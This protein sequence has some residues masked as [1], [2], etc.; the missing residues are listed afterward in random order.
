MSVLN[1]DDEKELLYR[2]QAGKVQALEALYHKHKK[3]LA[4]SLLKLLKDETLAEDVLQESF[5]RVW[6]NHAA[7]DPEKSFGAYLHRIAVNLVYD[8]YRRS[9]RDKQLSQHLLNHTTELYTHIEERLV[10][11]E[12]LGLLRK[13]LEQLPPQ[14]R[15]VFELFKLEG[16]SYREIS[17]ELGISKATINSHIT[18]VNQFLRD[19]LGN[20][21]MGVVLVLPF[22]Y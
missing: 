13:L 22:L 10:G 20:H 5:I 12:R 19:R 6:E 21:M 3:K 8:I 16:K 7:I 17:A 4:L 2:L 18:K 11:Q 9:A 15:K 14:R 1:P